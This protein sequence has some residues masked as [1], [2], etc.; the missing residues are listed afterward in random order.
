MGRKGGRRYHL[1]RRAAHA[2]PTIAGRFRG[3]RSARM[4]ILRYMHPPRVLVAGAMTCG[5]HRGG[6]RP[7]APAV[8]AGDPGAS[9]SASPKAPGIPQPIRETGAAQGVARPRAG[10]PPGIHLPIPPFASLPHPACLIAPS[11]LPHP[12]ASRANRTPCPGPGFFPLQAGW[13]GSLADAGGPSPTRAPQVTLPSG[14]C[15]RLPRAPPSG[16]H[17]RLQC[18]RQ[19]RVSGPPQPRR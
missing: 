10:P 7:A 12:D 3:L 9:W 2:R 19:P 15:S 14:G 11:C 16:Y 8:T 5:E 18:L 17:E 6:D 4:N 13:A 1:R